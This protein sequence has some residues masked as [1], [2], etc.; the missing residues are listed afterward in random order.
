LPLL[1]SPNLATQ[2]SAARCCGLL[3]SEHLPIQ[4][5]LWHQKADE[6]LAVLLGSDSRVTQGW[7]QKALLHLAIC[8][9]SRAAIVARLVSCLGGRSTSAQFKAAEALADLLERIPNAR[10]TIA[11]EGA[12]GPLVA[13]LG[14]GQRAD[15]FTPPER[16]AAVLAEVAKL[17]E[18]KG[19]MEPDCMPDWMWI[20]C[21]IA[22]RIWMWI[23]C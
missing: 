4:L 8:S 15:R 10:H 17:H 23:A 16:A 11:Q 5:A 18:S 22:C 14:T 1:S 20:A 7:A 19:E 3:A 21:R 9:E 6:Q 2:E 13:L 12:V